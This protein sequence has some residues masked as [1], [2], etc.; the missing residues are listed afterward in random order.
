MIYTHRRHRHARA[1]FTL[2]KVPYDMCQRSF[3][4]RPRQPCITATVREQQSPLA[5]ITRQGSTARLRVYRTTRSIQ[6]H[7]VPYRMVVYPEKLPV[8]LYS[9]YLDYSGWLCVHFTHIS[10]ICKP[11][12]YFTGSFYRVE[13]VHF[14]VKF[15]Y[16]KTMCANKQLAL[17]YTCKMFFEQRKIKKL[18]HSIAVISYPV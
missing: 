12:N 2:G 11:K 6:Y 10:Y 9:D 14:Q 5:A 17:C 18:K 1:C 4:G 13:K 15:V 3:A 7:N 8:T 16:Y